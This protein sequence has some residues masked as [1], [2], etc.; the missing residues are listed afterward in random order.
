MTEEKPTIKFEDLKLRGCTASLY[1]KAS[2]HTS[3]RLR[4]PRGLQNGG[5]GRHPSGLGTE[6][7]FQGVP[8]PLSIV[9]LGSHETWVSI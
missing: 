6:K 8:L 2:E 1:R 5:L 3:F 9:T 4:A 7:P